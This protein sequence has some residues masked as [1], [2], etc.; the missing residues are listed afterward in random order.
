M[1]ALGSGS[2]SMPLSGGY[3]EFYL[4]VNATGSQDQGF[5]LKAL[6]LQPQASVVSKVGEIAEKNNLSYSTKGIR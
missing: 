2:A 5:Y 6:Y 1:A 3:K 4:G